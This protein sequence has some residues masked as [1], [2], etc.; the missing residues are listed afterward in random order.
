MEAVDLRPLS[1]GELLD[2]TFRLYRSHFWLFVGIMAIPAAFWLPFNVLILGFQGS[3]MSSSLA[4][5]D[6]PPTLPNVGLIAGMIAGG[7]ALLFV[8]AIVYSIAVAAASSAVSEVYLGRSI[9]V[10]GSYTRLRGRFWKLMGIVGNILLRV[11]GLMAVV[12][13]VLVGGVFGIGLLFSGGRGN[14]IFAAFLAIIILIAYVGGL[15]LCVY[16]WLR[17]AVSIPVLMIENP[18]VLATIRRSVFLTRGRRGQIFLTLLVAMIIAYAGIFVFQIPFTIAMMVSMSQG[19]WSQP[20][21]F[22]S[23]VA[24]A[25][26]S[27]LTGPISMIAIV[28]LYY[29]S[30]IR[31]EA[32]DL[33]FMMASLDNPAPPAGNVAPA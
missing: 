26:G 9:T 20:L 24:G 2:R 33:Q 1:L 27:S 10:R 18:G 25:V 19:H 16:L 23:A 14:P 5:P 21:A 17:Y 6:Q 4:A 3:M 11:V 31:K 30:R 15:V 7:L 29:D 8:A 28:L 22:A 12:M 32:F 13:G